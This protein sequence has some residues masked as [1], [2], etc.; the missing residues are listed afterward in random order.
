MAHHAN[1]FN[2]LKQRILDANDLE[3]HFAAL[4]IFNELATRR[5]G[6]DSLV[7]DP[8]GCAVTV[9]KKAPR[10]ATPKRKPHEPAITIGGDVDLEAGSIVDLFDE[11]EGVSPHVASVS[12]EPSSDPRPVPTKKKVVSVDGKTKNA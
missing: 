5:L 7:L 10:K 2:D 3:L 6:P 8:S 4:I 1:S 11:A 12:P 9:T